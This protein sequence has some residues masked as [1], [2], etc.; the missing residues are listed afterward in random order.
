VTPLTPLEDALGLIL[1]DASCLADI[2]HCA[3]PA[4][5]G[6]VLAEDVSAGV[7][8]PYDDNSA[9]DG[10]ALRA[11]DSGKSL[12]VAQ[13]I[14]AGRAGE[15]L[16]PGTAARIFTGA[17]VPPGA[18]AVAM[19]ENC[20]L[21]GDS[22]RLTQP[23]EPG[24]NIRRAGQDLASGSVVFTA[25]R[26]LQAED[27]G[28]LASVGCHDV[29]VRRRLVVSVLST[30]DEL[31]EPGPD[32]ELAPG[33]IFNSN[34]YTLIGL[35]SGLGCEV[36][37]G[38]MVPDDPDATAERLS[39]AAA[40]ADCVITTGGVSV[41]EEDHVKAQVERLGA[42]SLWKLQV[43]PGKPLAYGRIGETAFFGLPG[44]PA[45]VFVTFSMIVRPWLQRAQG[46]EVRNPLPLP[47]TARFQRPRAGKR[48]E[49]LRARASVAE[50]ELVVEVHE[51]QSSGVLSAVS[52]A[53]ALVVVPPGITVAAGDRVEVLLLDQLNR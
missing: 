16:A 1:A 7:P 41:G 42:L 34:R 38:G 15:P 10:Y 40:Q 46:A 18:D 24:E 14:A 20:E 39:V 35:L 33:Q 3:L 28:V 12:H 23:V 5:L 37:D 29:P 21:D 25:G 31:V 32:A 13:R 48:L 22:V 27:L 9:M 53:N 30:G 6:R 19:Q 11:A 44:N 51:N 52:W 49:F 45:A 26:R 43:K 4:A 8:V 17:P 47:A 36:R 50:G 2:E